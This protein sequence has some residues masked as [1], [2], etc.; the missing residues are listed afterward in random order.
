MIADTLLNWDKT[1]LANI[2]AEKMADAEDLIEA[3]PGIEM[4]GTLEESILDDYID[5]NWKLLLSCFEQT[6]NT[7]WRCF[8][9]TV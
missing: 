4:V 7:N 2:L 3:L 5:S 9:S 6:K 1:E 8:W